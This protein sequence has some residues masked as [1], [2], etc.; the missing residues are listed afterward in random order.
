MEQLCDV[1]LLLVTVANVNVR[2]KRSVVVFCPSPQS[3]IAAVAGNQKDGN[4]N[5]RY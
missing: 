1:F 3:C 2:S 5:G 4:W